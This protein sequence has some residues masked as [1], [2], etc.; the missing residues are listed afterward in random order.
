MCKRVVVSILCD[1]LCLSVA[2]S[3]PLKNPWHP[4]PSYPSLSLDPHS[5]CTIMY[6]AFLLT[7]GDVGKVNLVCKTNKNKITIN[8]ILLF[9][10]WFFF[11]GKVNFPAYKFLQE[12]DTI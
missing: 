9:L 6:L 12:I 7:D 11:Q 8:Y 5:S 10:I 1:I 3:I 2:H 4:N